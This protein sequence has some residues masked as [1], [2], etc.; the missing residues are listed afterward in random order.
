MKSTDGE[1]SCTEKNM[2]NK[3]LII[4]FYSSFSSGNIE[5][6]IECYHEEI[7][8][9][10]PAFVELKGDDVKNMWRML[11]ARGGEDI[12][13]EFSNIKTSENKG[14]ADWRAEYTYGPKKRKVINTVSAKFE[15]KDGKIIKHS[16][17][18]D[19]WKWSRMALGLSGYLLG[20]SPYMQNKIRKRTNLLLKRFI[21]KA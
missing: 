12:K 20:W 16:D 8:F 19:M 7:V 9:Q 17:E 14:S 10:D 2:D 15:F 21:D 18:F 13:I 11:S 6:M 3:E 1:S 5:G 4:R